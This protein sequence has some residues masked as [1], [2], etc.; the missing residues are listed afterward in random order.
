MSAW[1]AKCI[2]SCGRAILQVVKNKSPG[3]EFSRVLPARKGWFIDLE[4]TLR[5]KTRQARLIERSAAIGDFEVWGTIWELSWKMKH[6]GNCSTADDSNGILLQTRKS[7]AVR[8]QI[9]PAQPKTITHLPKRPPVDLAF[10]DLTY[11]V[12]EGRKN[13]EY[14]FFFIYYRYLNPPSAQ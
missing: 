3:T 7:S 5:R 11:K 9:M 10:T 8:L 12:R 13:S 2:A 6:E 4:T 1:K 14:T